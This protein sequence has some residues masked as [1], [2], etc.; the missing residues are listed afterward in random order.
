MHLARLCG[1][2]QMLGGFLLLCAAGVA[3]PPPDLHLELV[4]DIGEGRAMMVRSP[5][6]GSNRLFIICSLCAVNE[7]S[8][9][10]EAS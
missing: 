3:Q 2:W 9:D 10:I 5:H 4:T 8:L 6:D 7:S 1:C